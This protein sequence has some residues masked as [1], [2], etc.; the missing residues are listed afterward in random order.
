MIEP[1][2]SEDKD[3][4]DRFIETMK[5]IRE[6]IREVE[7]GSYPK[8]DNVLVN[9]PHTQQDILED[10][11]HAYSLE[12]AIFPSSYQKEVFKFWPS[13]SRVN[14]AVGDR[15]LICTCPDISSYEEE[16]QTS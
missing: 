14:N 6:E 9:A 12:K 7:Q 15:N 13:V 1:T 11:Q 4:I 8:D 5:I 2:E 16:V 3:E 10:W